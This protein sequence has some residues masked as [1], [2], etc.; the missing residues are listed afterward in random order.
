[1]YIGKSR[2]CRFKSN[3][4]Y[5]ISFLYFYLYITPNY[6][7]LTSLCCGLQLADLANLTIPFLLPQ[8]HGDMP[9]GIPLPNLK[10]S[11]DAPLHIEDFRKEYCRLMKQPYPL[12]G[13]VFSSS[14]MMFRVS[15]LF[16]PLFSHIHYPDAYECIPATIDIDY[17][18]RRRCEVCSQASFLGKGS[19]SG[20]YVPILGPYSDGSHQ[21]IRRRWSE[22]G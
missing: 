6:R 9:V 21:R 5:I 20:Q 1:M 7:L 22:E 13:A 18:T 14:W 17:H 12:E 11:P 15:T 2:K 16:R 4:P 3:F 8:A 10:D 19:D